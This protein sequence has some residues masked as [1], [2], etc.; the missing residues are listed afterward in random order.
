[1]PIKIHF[2]NAVISIL[3]K[4]QRKPTKMTLKFPQSFIIVLQIQ[5]IISVQFFPRYR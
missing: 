5:K 2:D 3:C 1:M 4:N